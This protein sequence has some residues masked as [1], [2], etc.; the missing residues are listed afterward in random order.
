MEYFINKELLCN[1]SICRFFL[2]FFV[3]LKLVLCLQNHLIV[4][5]FFITL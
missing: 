1:K 5:N 3:L 4:Y 2:G